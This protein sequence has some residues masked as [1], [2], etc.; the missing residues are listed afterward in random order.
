MSV[1]IEIQILKGSGKKDMPFMVLYLFIFAAQSSLL[2][3]KMGLQNA[4][5]ALFA[6]SCSDKTRVMALNSKK[7]D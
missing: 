5:E 6:G 4:G 1:R 2:V 3:P 7:G